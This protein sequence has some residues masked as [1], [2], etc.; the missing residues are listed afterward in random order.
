MK[1]RDLT[2]GDVYDAWTLDQVE[3]RPNPLADNEVLVDAVNGAGE[4]VEVAI[5]VGDSNLRILTNDDGYR[6]VH[7]NL[8]WEQYEVIENG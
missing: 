5:R 8:D 4:P 7:P 3:T 1:I 2:S 6:M